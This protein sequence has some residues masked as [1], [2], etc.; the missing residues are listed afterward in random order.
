[1]GQLG[2]APQRRTQAQRTAATRAAL[3][4]ATVDCLVESGYRGTT[5]TAVA[6]RAGVSHGAL[7]HHFPTKADLIGAAIAHLIEQRTAEFRK[8]M[9]DLPPQAERA[10]AAVDLLWSI[11]SGPTFVA[12]LELWVAARTDPEIAPVAV[13]LDREFVSSSEDVFREVFAEETALNPDLPRLA[14]G[15][16]FTY[17]TGLATGRLA[18]GYEPAPADELLAVFKL[19]IAPALPA[20]RTSSR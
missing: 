19:L 11:F 9:A 1:M 15:V 18:P 14:V 7:L 12:W 16:V 2:P 10:A 13:R 5:T 17:L 4:G 6:G 3:L 8:A 20:E